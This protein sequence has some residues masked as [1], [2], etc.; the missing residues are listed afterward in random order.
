MSR[1]L[2]RELGIDDGPLPQVGVVQPARLS[3][4]GKHA[5]GDLLLGAN[6]DR[7]AVDGGLGATAEEWAESFGDLELAA[8]LR[9][10]P[11]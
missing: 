4:V 2:R 11:A 10:L 3:Q 6:A 9:S 8:Y 7:K 1:P 5:A